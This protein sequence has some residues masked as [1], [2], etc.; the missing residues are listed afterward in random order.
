M[1]VEGYQGIMPSYQGQIRERQL[2]AL[3]A[4]IKSLK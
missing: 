3:I 2:V 1:V 4:Y